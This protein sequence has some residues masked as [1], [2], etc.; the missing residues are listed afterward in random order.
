[1]RVGPMNPRQ[2]GWLIAHWDEFAE[3]DLG[4]RVTFDAKRFAPKRTGALA[5]SIENHMTGDVLIIA[6]HTS[7]AA[8]VE[9]GTRPHIIRAHARTRGGWTGPYTGLPGPGSHS[10]RWFGSGGQAFFAMVVHHPGTR[11]HPYLRA[12]LL[13]AAE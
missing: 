1:M 8:F 5:A 2:P 11:P 13:S 10:L 9:T 12:A 4:P 6:A 3:T 7:Y